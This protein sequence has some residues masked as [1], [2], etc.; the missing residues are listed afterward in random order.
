MLANITV[1][2]TIPQGIWK[3]TQITI[4]RNTDG[5]IE[6]VVHNSAA[7]VQSFIPSFNELEMD[8]QNIVLRYDSWEERAQYNISGNQLIVLTSVARQIYEYSMRGENLV[9]TAV[10]NY[11]YNLPTGQTQQITENWTIVLKPK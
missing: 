5:N 2:A 6:T 9:L 10:Y 8:A 7:E 11:L 1:Q 3:V 4:E